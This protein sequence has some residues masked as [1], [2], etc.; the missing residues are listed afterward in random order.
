CFFAILTQQTTTAKKIRVSLC[1]SKSSTAKDRGELLYCP[2]EKASIT[3]V[4]S[5][6]ISL[7]GQQRNFGY[8]EKCVEFHHFSPPYRVGQHQR[9][10]WNRHRILVV[11]VSL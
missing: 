7:W 8:S 1:S 4:L 11:I 10:A 6:F 9:S 3:I 2:L 5:M